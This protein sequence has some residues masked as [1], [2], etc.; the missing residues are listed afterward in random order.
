[1]GRLWTL[2]PAQRLRRRE[3]A[4]LARIAKKNKSVERKWMAEQKALE[5]KRLA[6]NP[7]GEPTLIER[8]M[9]K[10]K[11]VHFLIPRREDEKK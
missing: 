6:E 9:G 8:L 3:C 11:P 7:W 10:R 2:T 5:A 4:A 1:M